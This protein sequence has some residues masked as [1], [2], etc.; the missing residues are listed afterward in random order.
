M[1]VYI[2]RKNKIDQESD[3]DVLTVLFRLLRSRVQ[4]DF[5][6]YKSTSNVDAFESAWCYKGTVCSV[7]NGELVFAPCLL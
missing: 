4:M 3:Y 6:F 5:K 1:A 2:S 7:I